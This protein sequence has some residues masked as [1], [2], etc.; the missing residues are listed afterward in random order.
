MNKLLPI[1]LIV[2][3]SACGGSEEDARKKR[4]KEYGKILDDA[5]D[6]A[7][8]REMLKYAPKEDKGYRGDI[9]DTMPDS[10]PDASGG[11]DVY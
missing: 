7:R 4:I 1:L 9:Y 3:L 2:V 11:G 6:R 5:Q 10:D 8:I